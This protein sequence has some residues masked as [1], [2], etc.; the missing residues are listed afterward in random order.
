MDA[1][2][3]ATRR[4]SFIMQVISSELCVQGS[5]TTIFKAEHYYAKCLLKLTSKD[6]EPGE[7]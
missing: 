7:L 1:R 5:L 4:L 2:G 6:L 3:V